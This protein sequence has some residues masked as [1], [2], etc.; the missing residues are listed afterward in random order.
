[1]T[2]FDG[3]GGQIEHIKYVNFNTVLIFEEQF[4]NF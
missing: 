1:M 3:A 2:L 4:V